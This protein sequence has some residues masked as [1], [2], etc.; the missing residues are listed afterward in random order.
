MGKEVEKDSNSI[1]LRMDAGKM[2]VEARWKAE[3]DLEQLSVC[4]GA[5][6]FHLIL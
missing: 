5:V 2:L 1:E 4:Y 3:S 6:G